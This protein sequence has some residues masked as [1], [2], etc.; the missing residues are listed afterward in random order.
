M[1]VHIEVTSSGRLH[2]DGAFFVFS[3]YEAH[4]NALINWILR[5]KSSGYLS[6]AEPRGSAHAASFSLSESV[7]VGNILPSEVSVSQTTI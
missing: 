7:I 2:R 3:V 4:V 1:M 5:S 6:L